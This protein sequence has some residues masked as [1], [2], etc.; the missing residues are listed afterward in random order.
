MNGRVFA[1]VFVVSVVG[2]ADEVLG[3][4]ELFGVVSF[5]DGFDSLSGFAP[6]LGVTAG[7]AVVVTAVDVAVVCVAVLEVLSVGVALYPFNVLVVS[8]PN[9]VAGAASSATATRSP[10]NAP[11]ALLVI[12]VPDLFTARA[13]VEVMLEKPPTVRGSWLR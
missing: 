6:L 13:F 1:V 9:A 4:T 5:V 8:A 7:L 12:V 2:D 11:G 10:S 3:F